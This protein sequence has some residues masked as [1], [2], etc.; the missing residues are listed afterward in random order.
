MLGFSVGIAVCNLQLFSDK[1]RIGKI[2]F[3]TLGSLLQ[4]M[5]GFD[6]G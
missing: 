4:F 2:S 1:D 6:F 3:R 5:S